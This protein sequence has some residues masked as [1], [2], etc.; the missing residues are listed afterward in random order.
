MLQ[1]EPLQVI[2]ALRIILS[3]QDVGSFKSINE[4]FSSNFIGSTPL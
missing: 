1:H 3:K 2:N 4:T